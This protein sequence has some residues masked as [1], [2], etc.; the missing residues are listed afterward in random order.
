MRETRGIAR[1]T[2]AARSN[3]GA[4]SQPVLILIDNGT[5]GAAE[6]FA[7]G[8]SGN[9]RGKLVGER[10]LGRAALQKF[11]RLPDGAGMVVSNGWYLTPAGE[12]IH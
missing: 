12:P 5:S 7:A 1:E 3:D 4:I 11:V 10:T 2:I 6:L 9:Q 8:I